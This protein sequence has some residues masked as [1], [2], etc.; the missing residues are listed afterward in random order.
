MRMRTAEGMPR[1]P[2]NPKNDHTLGTVGLERV[3]SSS[4]LDQSRHK[5]AAKWRAILR[6]LIKNVSKT[7]DHFTFA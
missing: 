5:Q 7:T 3:D 6:F 1:S 4:L 2:E